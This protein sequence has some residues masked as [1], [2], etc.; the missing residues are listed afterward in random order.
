M[1]RTIGAG[2]EALA[3]A[4]AGTR[5]AHLRRRDGLP[6]RACRPHRWAGGVAGAA[7]R[8]GRGHR[9]RHGQRAGAGGS[10]PRL[11]GLRPAGAGLR[12]RLAGTL[13]RRHRRGAGACADAG[14]GARGAAGPFP[15]AARARGAVLCRLHLRLD[16]RA[17][18]L[19]PQPPLLDRQL[20]GQRRRVRIERARRGDGA[21]RARR[22]AASL[23]RRARAAHRRHRGD[24]AP[25]PPAPRAAP[26]SPAMASP[27]STPRRRN[28]RCS[29][30][31]PAATP[32]R[33][34][35]SS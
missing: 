14:H 5:R 3:A 24:D 6:R 25:V 18:G 11:R 17:E 35:A 9:A 20:R 7:H 23:W 27:R 28:C 21:W 16:R 15:C 29:S 19:S 8:T 1:A 32:S 26:R 22:L 4:D 12:S 13:P 34:C 2:L 33:A 30:R 31:R 10:L